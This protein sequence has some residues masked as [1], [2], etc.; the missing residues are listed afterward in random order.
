LERHDYRLRTIEKSKVQKN[1]EHRRDL[2][3][4]Q[5]GEQGRRCGS[6][7]LANQYGYDSCLEGHHATA[8]LMTGIYEKGVKPCEKQKAALEQRLQRSLKLPLYDILTQPK[9]AI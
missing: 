6:S 7:N 3:K 8:N 1:G 2:R 9:T 5:R 4:R